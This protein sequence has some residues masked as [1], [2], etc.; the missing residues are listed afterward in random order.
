MDTTFLQFY[1]QIVKFIKKTKYYQNVFLLHFDFTATDNIEQQIKNIKNK[2]S[3][4]GKYCFV[5]GSQEPYAFIPESKIPISFIK[6]ISSLHKYKIYGH[7]FIITNYMHNA[8]KFSIDYYNKN[9]YGWH[10]ESLN[11]KIPTITTIKQSQIKATSNRDFNLDRIK[12][13]ISYLNF[14]QRMHRQLFSK[15]LIK[16]NLVKN[17]LVAINGNRDIH[18]SKQNVKNKL[19]TYTIKQLTN[20]SFAD[21]EGWL[22][23]K[24]WLDIWKDIPLELS[25]HKDIDDVYDAVNCQFLQNASINF[26]SETVFSYPYTFT[27]EK[28]AQP[29]LAKRPFFLIGPAGS[30]KFLQKQ[31]FKTFGRVLDES[32][33]SIVDPNQRLE[34]LCE[35]AQQINKLSLEDT[36][37]MVKKLEPEI[38]HNFNLMYSNI[39]N[40]QKNTMYSIIKYVNNRKNINKR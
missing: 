11:L 3:K 6:L 28:L 37:N 29:I 1:K 9:A 32:Y 36:V 35:L 8:D 16:Y 30:L 17:N 23:N 21:Y 2:I 19:K 22:Y 7:D 34:K 14:T 18:T 15:F 24:N 38:T 12:Y 13:K 26:V 25:K 20:D 40:L 31:G 39:K 10:F 27:S 4:K 33:D 5:L